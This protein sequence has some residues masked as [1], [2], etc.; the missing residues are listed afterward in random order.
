MNTEFNGLKLSGTFNNDEIPLD[1]KAVSSRWVYKCK[2]DTFGRV[3]QAKA[4]LVA[5]GFSQVHGV[6]Y[7]DMFSPTP[8]MTSIRMLAAFACEHKRPL[9]HLD[10]EQAYIQSPLD[11]R[12]FLRLPQG[13]GCLLY[14]SPSPRDA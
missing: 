14:T 12:I 11:E 9:W 1:R 8:A 7:F 3:I 13:C 5:K 10:V 6:D 4:R 2:T